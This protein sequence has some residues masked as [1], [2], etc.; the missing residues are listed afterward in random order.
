MGKK[1]IRILLIED[2]P[3]DVEIIRRVLER[4]RRLNFELVTAE[5]TKAGWKLLSKE[6]FDAVL[7]DHKLPGEN[8]LELLRCQSGKGRLPPVIMLTGQVDVVVAKEAI[9]HGAYDYVPKESISSDILGDA[10]REAVEASVVAHELGGPIK[11]LQKLAYVDEPTGLYNRRYLDDSLD[12]EC[13]IALRYDQ[14]LSCLMINLDDFNDYN[15]SYGQVDG[16]M[17]LRQVALA[18]SASLGDTD[19]TTRYGGDEFCVLLP[20]TAPDDAALVAERIRWAVVTMKLVVKKASINASVS[21]GVFTPTTAQQLR[22]EIMLQCAGRA[23]SRAKSEG[24]NKVCVYESAG[25][26][27][28][29]PDRIA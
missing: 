25:L 5:S 12:R 26:A 13:R 22:P 8:G 19:I 15:D 28:L 24:K 16:D 21:I 29:A 7:L 10:I 2:N 1:T 17:I 23:L 9:K 18:I 14:Y 4:Y 6:A 27:A 3:D 11:D 20:Q